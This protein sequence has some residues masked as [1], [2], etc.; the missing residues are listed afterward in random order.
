MVLSGFKQIACFV[1]QD[2]EGPLKINSVTNPLD[3]YN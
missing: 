3:L 1:D 2:T